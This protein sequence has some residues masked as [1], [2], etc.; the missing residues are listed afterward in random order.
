M[1]HAGRRGMSHCLIRMSNCATG[2]MSN[3]TTEHLFNK[4]KISKQLP[5]KLV[6][7]LAKTQP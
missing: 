3:S 6:E 7:V 5:K 4:D 2:G 1:S